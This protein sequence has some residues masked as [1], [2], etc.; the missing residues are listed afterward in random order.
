M[1]VIIRTPFGE[2]KFDSEKTPV[3]IEL[4][5]QEKQH[6]TEMLPEA[7]RYLSMPSEGEFA[8]T[9]EDAQAFIRTS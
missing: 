1:K 9:I 4:T 2:L 5:D 8:L 3:V 7:H 6:I